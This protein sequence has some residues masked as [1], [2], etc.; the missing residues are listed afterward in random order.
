MWG[1][2]FKILRDIHNVFF[3]LFIYLLL[4][5]TSTM[6]FIVELEIGL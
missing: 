4:S 5:E 6:G 1:E 3:A 2:E